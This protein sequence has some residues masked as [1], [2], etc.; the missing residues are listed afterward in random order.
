MWARPPV[1]ASRQL[2]S[3]LCPL[4]P[5]L[6]HR[7]EAVSLIGRNTLKYI[8]LCVSI[9]YCYRSRVT[10]TGFVA[11]LP[12]WALCFGFFMKKKKKSLLRAFCVCLES[13][14]PVTKAPGEQQAYFPLKLPLPAELPTR[15]CTR[16]T[17]PTYSHVHGELIT[18]AGRDCVRASPARPCTSATR[19]KEKSKRIE[20]RKVDFLKST[21]SSSQ[22]T[23]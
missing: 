21:A 7:A 9:F 4:S 19:E 10:I 14:V 11:L 2:P 15:T 22:K 18:S 3:L 16:L 20:Q 12:S 6:L 5:L 17:C 23:N 8:S 13:I 1:P